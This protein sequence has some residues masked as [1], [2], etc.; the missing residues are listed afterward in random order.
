M[1]F[2]GQQSHKTGLTDCLQRVFICL[3]SQVI[4]DLVG[5]LKGNYPDVLGEIL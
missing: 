3:L 5:L 2:L 1:T 4:F